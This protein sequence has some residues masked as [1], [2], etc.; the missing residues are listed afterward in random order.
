MKENK[1]PPFDYDK[2]GEESELAEKEKK[3]S[4]TAS[5]RFTLAEDEEDGDMKIAEPPAAAEAVEAAE[6]TEENTTESIAEAKQPRRDFSVS[7][8]KELKTIPDYRGPSRFQRG[9]HRVGVFAKIMFGLII[10]ILSVG[11]ALA[12]L[13]AAQDV[14]GMGKEQ[15]TYVIEIK[16]NSGLAQ[17]AQT[18]EEQGVINSAFLFK[19][20]YK[21]TK[22]DVA[23]QYGSY[24]LNSGMSY[25]T[26]L[27][28]LEKYSTVK[29]EV[30]VQI[31]EGMTLF[32]IAN[33]LENKKVCPADEFIK[34]V[35]ETSFDYPFIK[36]ISANSLRFHK[37]E[38]YLF[39][40]TYNF[41]V[42]DNPVNVAKK[43][44]NNYQKRTSEIMTAGLAKSGLTEEEAII[45]ASIVQLEAGVKEMP[46]VA[47]VYMNRFNNPG[48][49]ARLQ[50][51]PTRN[52][53]NELKIQMGKID[54]E[55]IDAYNTY[56][57]LGLPPGPICNPGI[58]AINA[59]LNP[60]DTEYF[61]FCNNLKTGEYFYAQTLEEHN[62]NVKKAGLRVNS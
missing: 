38:G 45:L 34:A 18:L 22:A 7:L 19:A 2:D 50:A 9:R 48:E 17:V 6:A 14:M 5:Y 40:D 13:F 42:G 54:Q 24:S 10:V 1:F 21:F 26:I 57:G 33:E 11:L 41:F 61:Y 46:N 56:E 59:I 36:S 47:S 51:D 35:N 62:K 25:G 58:D 52:Y 31:T 53:A 23:F 39:P 44:F 37:M 8:D 30:K 4:D 20:Y 12:I 28:E 49:Y 16:Q 3:L 60:A 32:Q 55:I 15:G 43:F 27:D 29:E